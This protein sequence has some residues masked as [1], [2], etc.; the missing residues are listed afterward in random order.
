[1]S[2]R[3]FRSPHPVTAAERFQEW[4]L[5]FQTIP[6]KP[7]NFSPS[8]SY[9][10]R[11]RKYVF[12]FQMGWCLNTQARRTN[13][14][15]RVLAVIFNDTILQTFIRAD[16]IA[17][18]TSVVIRYAYK[19]KAARLVILIYNHFMPF[20]FNYFNPACMGV[21]L[22]ETFSSFCIAYLHSISLLHHIYISA[23]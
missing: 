22:L 3:L 1:M 14:Q 10:Y 7:V 12:K 23:F 4:S 17:F 20:S 6:L 11:N 15:T 18:I 8:V 9:H 13:K 5:H 21:D 19:P 2:M 16:F